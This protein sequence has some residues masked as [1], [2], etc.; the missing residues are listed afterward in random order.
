MQKHLFF[1]YKAVAFHLKEI[2]DR[3]LT[4]HLTNLTAVSTLK[5]PPK[6]T[7]VG[8]VSSTFNVNF[9][10]KLCKFSTPDVNAVDLS[11]YKSSHL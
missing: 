8:I 2:F 7:Y 4:D 10:G 6:L 1:P 3:S 5:L 11:I 9:S